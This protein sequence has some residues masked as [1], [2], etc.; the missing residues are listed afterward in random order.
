MTDFLNGGGIFI[1][2]SP[3]P[4]II[5]NTEMDLGERGIPVNYVAGDFWG[6]ATGVISPVLITD[7][8]AVG[9]YATL[10]DE[11][12][13]VAGKILSTGF[14]LSDTVSITKDGSG[15]MIFTDVIAGS[16]TLAQLI[17]AGS[18]NVVSIGTPTNLQLA[19]WT[20]STSIQGINISS[21]TLAQS[22]ITNLVTDLSGKAATIHNLVDIT[23]HPVSG[24]TTGHFLKALSATSYGFSAHGLTKTDVGLSNV[25][26]HA[27]I[28]KI[29][30]ATNN[31]VARWDGA[32]GDQIKD[33]SVTMGD[34]G[35]INIPFGATFNI[36]GVNHTHAGQYQILDNTLTA[37]AALDT[38][39]GFIYQTGTDLF[40][41]YEFAGSGS[42][43]TIARSDHNHSGLYITGNQTIT[44]S[45]DITGS[46]TIA[47]T[48]TLATVNSNV[49][50]TNS[51]LKFSVN[52]KGLVT[53]AAAIAEADIQG[54]FGS[55]TA[56]FVY[57]A[58]NGSAGNAT[59]RLLVAA[60]IPT[61]AQSQVTNLV[62]DLSGKQ[63]ADAKLT[64]YAALSASTG[65]LYNNGSGVL[66]WTTPGGGNVSNTGTPTNGQLAQW[67][68]STTIQGIAVNSLAT[69]GFGALSDI[70]TNNATVSAHGFLPKLGGGTTNFLRADGTW[71]APGATA[72]ADG[73]WDWDGSKY[74]PYAAKQTTLQHFYL[75]TS[76]PDQTTRMNFDGYLYA[77]QLYDNGTRVLTAIPGD[78][79]RTGQV[80]TYGDFA[81]TFKDDI[82]RINN[83]A[84]TFYY[85]IT[86]GAIAANRILNLPVITGTDTVAVLGLA[87]TFSAAKTFSS[88][89][90]L[91][92]NP[93]GTFAY[94][95]VGAAIAAARNITL[96]LLT[97]NDTMVTEAFG[98]TLTNK[99]I[100]ASS[101]TLTGVARTDAANT[102]GDFNNIFRSSR[103]I[104]SNPGNT[105]NYTFVGSAI[106]AAR[107]ITLPLLTGD[108]TI[109]T[110]AFAQTLT[111]K[112]INTTDNTLT[113]TSQAAGDLL[114]NNGTKFVRFG[115]GSGLQV[116]RTNT[117]A[118][119]LEWISPPWST[120]T[121]A[122][123]T[124]TN[125]TNVT[126]TLGGTPSTALLQAA[127]ITLG[128]TGTLADGRIASA[129]T[130][131]AKQAGSAN[132]TSVSGL[133]YVSASFVKMTAAN[134]FTLD[135]NT[136]SL[137][138][139]T[140]AEST[141]TFT[142][143]T[144]NN[145]TTGQHGYL[146]KLGGGTTNFLRADGA[147]AAPGGGVT[148]VDSTLLDWS[149]DRYQPYAAASTGAFDTS[150][151]DP[152]GTT[153]M[154]YGGYLYATRYYGD[155]Y[156]P[157]GSL[158][159]L[160]VQAGNA[161][162]GAGTDAGNLVL[163]A[164]NA[165]N[166]DAASVEG[167]IF[168]APGNPYQ[169]QAANVYLGGANYTPTIIQLAAYGT[170]T[171]IS[172]YITPKGSGNITIGT[173]STSSVVLYGTT[174]YITSPSIILNYDTSPTI[175]A[176]AG[177]SGSVTGRSITIRGG[178]AYNTG[179]N[180]GGSLYFYGGAGNGAGI[181]GNIYLG[182]GSTGYLPAKS[183]ETN[184]V[185]YDTATGKLSYGVPSSMTYPGAGIAIST[186]S[187][188]GTSITPSTGYLYYNGSAYSWSTPSGD[189]IT[190]TAAPG[191]DHSAT[192]IKVSLT[193][194]ETL[195]IGD[196]V[197]MKSDG[198]VW[199]ADADASGLY[200]AVAICLAGA[201]ANASVEVL[202]KGI[203]RDDTWAWSVG[204]V[205]YLSTTAGG[206][207]QT[208]PTGS[209]HVVQVIGVA[210]HAD[211]MLF[212]PSLDLITLL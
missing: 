127:S 22:Q 77:T 198:K 137:S 56:N 74:A 71:A 76:A 160:T 156:K 158:R 87:Q 184:V 195:V 10:Y 98:Q 32:S 185:Y 133:S 130:W 177:Y 67:T 72:P 115:I 50:G 101:N 3:P 129:A 1:G 99:T 162:G 170:A 33:S 96:P 203:M 187:A 13:Y 136:Y 190:L 152:S 108:D 94:T 29:V 199:K 64:T 5:P 46:G 63:T 85:I 36:N 21:L 122:A 14:I 126:I 125:D 7:K 192:G 43:N 73:I 182:N 30:S 93:G 47:I 120:V 121:P 191:S 167:S 211:R 175:Q 150:S 144:T 57:A 153:R 100:A 92:N 61:I 89:S 110:I 65:Y 45:G 189:S 31:A 39:T 159:H 28:K 42:A 212:D 147:W 103:L 82:I 40:T 155:L 149:T 207:T 140:H 172:I 27:Q 163:Q 128:W 18:G 70:T 165:I 111:N 91:L 25:T 55:K 109:A 52:G 53:G 15:N 105:F 20:N 151:T 193:A 188:W 168:L 181:R 59:F 113:A 139:H 16:R 116:L 142:D 146:P 171:N 148:P 102:F 180:N 194:G 2:G 154:N 112:T 107:S 123:L 141:I 95:F 44:L 48:T 19:Q 78:V 12:L 119:D 38:S 81:Q 4:I 6:R 179:D 157:D 9:A 41:K 106:A 58:P 24:L 135:T 176:L 88:S 54:V 209:G 51:F 75:G 68:N 34:D 26:N 69:D 196:V 205:I 60:D 11:K 204:W 161:S 131:N 208:A 104:M 197:Y 206:L 35:S 37:L 173:S 166:A 143:I 200:P 84:D 17:G 86:A 132:L 145:A 138:S 210:T 118:T 23:N 62:L 66:S 186:G 169:N 90:L 114:K 201:S 83:P 174:A 97:G 117:G 164:G 178:N 49:Y 183:A 202:L 79:V 8:V 80:N 134:T 124:S